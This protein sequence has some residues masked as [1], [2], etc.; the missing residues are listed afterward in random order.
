MVTAIVGMKEVSASQRHQK[1]N[2]KFDSNQITQ[3]NRKEN[4][5][6]LKIH[7]RPVSF[8][9][10]LMLYIYLQALFLVTYNKF[11]VF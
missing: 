1:E 11:D 9:K 2:I 3:E 8:S 4:L 10:Y 7:F 5:L 6:N